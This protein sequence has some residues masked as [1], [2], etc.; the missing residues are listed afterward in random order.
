MDAYIADPLCG[1]DATVSLWIDLFALCYGGA[2][3]ERL[4]R[5]PKGLPV[6]LLG[7]SEDPATNGGRETRWLAERMRA[8]GLTDVSRSVLN[9]FRHETLNEVGRDA[10]TEAFAAWAL[11]VAARRSA[12]GH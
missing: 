6:H 4:A 7:G 11:G 2:S 1:F 9:G 5:L 10:A 8:A 3:R 12:G